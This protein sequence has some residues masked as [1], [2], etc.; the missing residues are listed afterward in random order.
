MKR[1]RIF[2]K[3][4]SIKVVNMT[5]SYSSLKELSRKTEGK[6]SWSLI[7]R[8]F[9]QKRLVSKYKKR[10]RLAAVI[11]LK[12]GKREWLNFVMSKISLTQFD[13]HLWWW[14]EV[15]EKMKKRRRRKEGSG[16][17]ISISMANQFPCLMSPKHRH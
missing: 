5:E 6:K 9:L 13:H 15:E 7:Q 3:L 17:S 10:N 14:E 4:M 16:F 8:S 1:I 2:E 11:K 12:V